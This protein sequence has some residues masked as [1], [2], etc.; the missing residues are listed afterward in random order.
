VA[1]SFPSAVPGIYK[2]Y[3]HFSGWIEIALMIF[4]NRLFMFTCERNKN[5]LNKALR[6]MMRP[7]AAGTIQRERPRATIPPERRLCIFF[8]SLFVVSLCLFSKYLEKSL[9]LFPPT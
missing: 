5:A 9:A 2:L 4:Q 3:A 8:L 6:V 7:F 1:S